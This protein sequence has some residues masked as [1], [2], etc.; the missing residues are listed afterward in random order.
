[1]ERLRRQ[2]KTVDALEERRKSKGRLDPQKV[3][4]HFRGRPRL[5][6]VRMPR[7]YG[8]R[9]DIIR[10]VARKFRISNNFAATCWKEYRKQ[11]KLIDDEIV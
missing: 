8:V 7:P 3:A 4:G 10:T 1:M 9:D 11:I 5:F 6:T 2:S